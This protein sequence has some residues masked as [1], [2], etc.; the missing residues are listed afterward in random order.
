MRKF[1]GVKRYRKQTMIY[2]G[3]A[4]RCL[5]PFLKAALSFHYMTKLTG[6]LQT[7]TKASTSYSTRVPLIFK[8]ITLLDYNSKLLKVIFSKE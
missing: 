4:K 5:S 3:P 8:K 1:K 7:F 2:S 6:V